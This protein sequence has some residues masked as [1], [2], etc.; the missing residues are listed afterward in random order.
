MGD[1]SIFIWHEWT[2][3]QRYA[4]SYHSLASHPEWIRGQYQREKNEGRVLWKKPGVDRKNI[5]GSVYRRRK[6]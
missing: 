3:D 5:A 1:K 6:R 2:D 4:I